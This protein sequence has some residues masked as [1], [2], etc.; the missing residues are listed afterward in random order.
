MQAI[1]KHYKD[2][3][4]ID[5]IKILLK[6]F[7]RS[8]LERNSLL[9]FFEPINLTTGELKTMNRNGNK[10]TPSKIASYN[11]LEFRIY[12]TGTI[13][14]TGSLHKY[15]NGGLHNFNDFGIGALLAVLL[16]LKIKFNIEPRQCVL[17]C[18]EIG[19][20]ITPPTATNE[21]LDN[22]LLHKTKPFEYKKN[23]YE[24]KYK[25]V[26]HSQYIVKIYNKA[27]H[28]RS[29]GY[30]IDH[31]VM[32]FE[33]KYTKMEK[34]N[35]KGVYTLQDLMDYGLFS[36]KKILL[37]EWNNVLFFDSTIQIDTLR[38]KRKITLLKYS[39]TNY[40]NGILL[41]KQIKNFTYHK[42]QLKKITKENSLK[43]QELTTA[44]MNEKIDLIQSKY[45]HDFKLM[46]C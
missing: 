25:Q 14:I 36:L 15:W 2:R 24:G 42:N 27:L 3:Q 5:F 46:F 44:I 12:D 13:I 32:R 20:N 4:L 31:E 8:K 26:E 19:I 39:N 1:Q 29:K 21:I 9:N 37:K 43:I 18:L 11:G 40:W 10:V 22:C 7:D 30:K 28:Y 45:N 41:N 33:I 34:L 35:K 16:D 6:D 23:S 17:R 38:K